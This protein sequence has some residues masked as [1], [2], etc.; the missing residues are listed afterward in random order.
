MSRQC[1]DTWFQP[2]VYQG[3]E[4]GILHLTVPT[5]SFK[6]CLLENYSDLLLEAAGEILKSPIRLCIFPLDPLP[7]RKPLSLCNELH[8]SVG[9]SAASDSEIYFRF[10][11]V[12]ASNQL[13]HAAAL[14]V[15]E[16]PSKAY[17]PLYLY[18]G[19]GLGKNASDARGG[20]S[21]PKA[22]QERSIGLYVFGKIH[23]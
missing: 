2:I 17:N 4:N 15:A 8:R 14:A 7:R 1:F 11:V 23:E 20:Q 6:K 19:V 5:E 22:E 12:G 9:F 3:R 10:F 21:H 16:R 13:A 18:G